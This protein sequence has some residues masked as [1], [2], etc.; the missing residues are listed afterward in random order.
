MDTRGNIAYF[1]SAEMPI[2]EDLQSGGI[3]G[4]PPYLIRNGSGGNEWL[5]IANPQ[6]HQAVPFE[7]LPFDEMP[8]L[9]NPV[10][11]YFINANN[12]PTGNT[13]DNN[14]FNELR[15]GGGIYYL[16]PGY[17]IGTRAG[18]ITQAF[19]ERLAQGPVEPC[20]LSRERFRSPDR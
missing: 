16:N 15:P 17:A 5:P 2:R 7:I 8:K 14:A 19:E 11:G 3:N 1:T 4:V 10:S 9:V 20:P 13:R 6:P 12:D 18:R